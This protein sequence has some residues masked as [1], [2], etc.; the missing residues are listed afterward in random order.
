MVF[1]GLMAGVGHSARALDKA[2]HLSSRS[3]TNPAKWVSRLLGRELY[4]R[5]PQRARV[6]VYPRLQTGDR[7]DDGNEIDVLVSLLVSFV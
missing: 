2:F 6:Q 3:D 1:K 7:N 4:A 5:L